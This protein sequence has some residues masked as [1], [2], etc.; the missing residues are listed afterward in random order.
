MHHAK[1]NNVVAQWEC[2]L[3]KIWRKNVMPCMSELE[4]IVAVFE[5]VYK[6]EE[7]NHTCHGCS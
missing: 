5:E 3:Q 2:T 7:M 6:V 1:S 4:E